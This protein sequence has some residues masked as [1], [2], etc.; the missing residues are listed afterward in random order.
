[1][2]STS[3]IRPATEADI[4]AVLSLLLTS[5]RQF[6]LFSFLYSPL[7]TN[8]D[9]AF[10]T[11]WVW[12]RRLLLGLLDPNA[13]IVVAEVDDDVPATLTKTEGDIQ[14]TEDRMVD[15]SW[16]M[17][18]WVTTRGG[19][20]QKSTADGKGRTIVGFAIWR[21]RVGE[22]VEKSETIGGKKGW[23]AMLRSKDTLL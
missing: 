9:A 5:F 2:S 11:I 1:M 23:I 4:P 3:S 10:D 14:R 6:S 17:L 20:T 19:L 8:K 16:K 7:N 15:E 13:A 12:R 18:E 21:V 22:K